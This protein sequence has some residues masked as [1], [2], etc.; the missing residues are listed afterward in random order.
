MGAMNT[1]V[2]ATLAD[3]AYRELRSRILAGQLASRPAACGRRSLRRNSAISPTPIKE[4]LL[5]LEADGLVMS[6]LRKGHGGSPTRRIAICIDI[7]DARLHARTRRD[8]TG[9]RAR[10]GCPGA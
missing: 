6:S 7:Y 5:R 3:Q 4:A 2:R 10:P 8:Q 9:L 1:V